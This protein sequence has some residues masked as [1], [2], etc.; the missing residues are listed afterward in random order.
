MS[1]TEV[2][3]TNEQVRFDPYSGE[4]ASQGESLVMIRQSLTGQLIVDIVN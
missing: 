2:P 3:A 4:V 1:M